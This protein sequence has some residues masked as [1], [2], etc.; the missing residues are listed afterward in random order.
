MVLMGHTGQGCVGIR[1]YRMVEW[2]SVGQDCMSMRA[3]N[4]AVW[5]MGAGLCGYGRAVWCT[6]V[7]MGSGCVVHCGAYGVGLCGYGGRY[8]DGAVWCMWGYGAQM[9]HMVLD[10]RRMGGQDAVVRW[11]GVC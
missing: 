3:Q 4:G 2:C 8:E 9:D 1:G 11:M 6:L 7:P 5:S 10:L